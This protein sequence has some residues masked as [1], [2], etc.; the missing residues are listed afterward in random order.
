MS[1]DKLAVE[2]LAHRDSVAACVMQMMADV[3]EARCLAESYRSKYCQLGSRG[4]VEYERL[5]V[6]NELPWENGGKQP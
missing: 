4:S 6:E 2:L 5:V 1:E 3:K